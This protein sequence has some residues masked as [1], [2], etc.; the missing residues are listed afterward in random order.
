MSLEFINQKIIITKLEAFA[1]SH[2]L[3]IHL[4]SGGIC[5]GLCHVY[6]KYCLEGKRNEFFNLLR[7]I[8]KTPAHEL[9]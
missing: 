1:Q 9:R 3:S 5:S 4:D 6:A 2:H 8:S 7:N